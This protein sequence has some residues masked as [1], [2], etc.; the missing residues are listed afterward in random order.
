MKEYSVYFNK[1][2]RLHKIPALTGQNISRLS[3]L[4]PPGLTRRLSEL[5]QVQ[6][7]FFPCFD[8]S[9]PPPLLNPSSQA[10]TAEE[11]FSER[12][13]VPNR[14]SIYL[15]S[16]F[17]RTL[18]SFCYYTVMPG[19]GI[20][21]AETYVDYLLREMAM[22]VPR[23]EGQLC[24]SIYFGGGTP[25][26]LDDKLLAR[27]FESLHANFN[28]AD[29]A[30]ITIEAAPGTL[31]AAKVD[32]LQSLGVN[33]LSYGIQTLD[34]DMLATMNRHYSVAEA[35]TELEYAVGTIGNVNIDTM[36][37]FEGEPEGALLDTLERFR[38]LGVPSLT[39]YSLD[40]QRSAH[41][42][43]LTPNKDN[44][45]ETKIRRF[46]E[47]KTMLREHGYRP[48]LQNVYAMPEQSSY[49][50]QTRRWENVPLVAMGVAS[51]GYAPRKPYQNHRALKSY[52][53]SIDAGELPISTVTLLS[54]EMEMAREITSRFRFTQVSIDQ[55]RRKYSVN[56][57][58]VFEH[59][60]ASL[61]ELGFL[62][63]R[64]DILKLTKE[65]DYYNNIIPML[66][67]PDAF[68][69]ELLGLPEEYIQEFPVPYVVTQ[70]GQTQSRPIEVVY[71]QSHVVSEDRRTGNER[72]TGEDRRAAIRIASLERRSGV[73]RR[74]SRIQVLTS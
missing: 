56:L 17:C 4:D 15:H 62:S 42:S 8:W 21:K 24:E 47:A 16:P 60:I 40:M 38:D 73:E 31:P 45:Y 61:A 65:A 28:L 37:G 7:D 71:P 68:K 13:V 25:T 27:I 52:Y 2:S 64:G 20:E 26:F 50:H 49:R 66:F 32:L 1:K 43:T 51:Q 35:V 5:L 29:D 34:A 30:E 69:E 58:E 12:S 70:V 14:Y 22:Y 39:I 3:S 67:A 9:F 54:P 53:G 36:Y 11:L 72:R 10:S 18:C 57:D 48:V 33:R 63:R 41:N 44:Q 23:L 46:N 59:L 74:A 6:N 19:K 55:I